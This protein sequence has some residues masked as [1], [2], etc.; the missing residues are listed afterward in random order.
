LAQPAYYPQP[1]QPQAMSEVQSIKSML[2]IA[3]LLAVIFGLIFLVLGVVSIVFGDYV[4]GALLILWGIVD[5]VIWTNIKAIEGLVNAGQYDAAKAK[6]LIWMIIGFILGGI[7]VGIL[8]LLAFLK[9]DPVI[10]AQRAQAGGMPPPGYG[11]PPPGYGAPPPGYAAPPPGYGAPPPAYAAP[12][13]VYAAPPQPAPAPPP[14][15]VAAP[16]AAPICPTCGQP[17][18]YVAQYSR[19]YCY[20]DKQYL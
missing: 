2:H 7:I 13:P 18:M 8:L 15:P 12:P 9:F 4:G 3:W 20:T 11:A 14:P 17:G 1:P 10:N 6:S 16:P 19:Y 5:F